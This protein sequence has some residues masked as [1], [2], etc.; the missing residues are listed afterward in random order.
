MELVVLVYQYTEDFPQS[1]KYG[2]VSQ[3]RRSAVSIPSNIAEGRRRGTRNDYRQF[4]LNAYG[5]GGEL[6]TQTE[7][8]KRLHFGREEKRQ[9]VEK[10]LDEV[11]RMLNAMITNLVASPKKLRS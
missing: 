7:I 5:S 3:M 4:L 11:M 10:M 8:T 9:A 2:L 6:E 1:E